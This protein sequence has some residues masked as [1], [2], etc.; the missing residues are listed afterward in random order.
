MLRRLQILLLFPVA[1]VLAAV[2]VLCVIEPPYWWAEP[3]TVATVQ[4]IPLAVFFALW[5]WLAGSRFLLV[6]FALVAATHAVELAYVTK[7]FM[8]ESNAYAEMGTKEL[9]I[10]QFNPTRQNEN[11]DQMVERLD[12]LAADYDVIAIQA[13]PPYRVSSDFL[14]AFPH[15][16]VD[17]GYYAVYSKTQIITQPIGGDGKSGGHLLVG[18][19][20]HNMQFVMLHS[21]IPLQQA[22][23][24]MRD[25]RHNSTLALIGKMEM[26]SFV[27]GD[28][29][30]TPYARTL[31]NAL[32][33]NGLKLAP[34]PYG[35]L[36]SW[37]LT[38]PVFLR[39]PIDLVIVNDR[40][41]V[42]KR[43]AV[44][45]PGSLHMAV[46]NLLQVRP[47]SASAN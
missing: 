34:F 22:Q 41:Q 21:W 1:L 39:F 4:Y 16:F 42:V 7:R 17:E 11:V 13:H 23:R 44:E 25:E 5:A 8:Q 27:I 28:F 3:L 30:Q 24:E 40:V 29:N 47:Y 37:P 12:E 38:L 18:L 35:V 2:T 19:P 46:S 10:L 36:P 45:I 20:Y 31:Q 14:R 6:V 15:R 43:E 26:P 9:R 33:E 32:A